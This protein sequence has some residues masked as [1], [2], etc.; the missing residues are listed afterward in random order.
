M[1]TT[2]EC[3]TDTTTEHNLETHSTTYSL[4]SF[5]QKTHTHRPQVAV[6]LADL[7]HQTLNPI[8]TTFPSVHVK[9]NNSECQD[10]DIDIIWNIL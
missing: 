5:L 10:M 6:E 9:G 7:C 2:F 4:S 8:P 1:S 3:W